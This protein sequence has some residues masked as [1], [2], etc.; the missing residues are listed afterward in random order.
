MPVTPGTPRFIAAMVTAQV[1]TQ[2]GGFTLPALPPGDM[3]SWSLSGTQAGWLI[4]IFFAA[5]VPF[6]A[7]YVPAVPVLLALTDRVPARR[8]C[9]VGT[10]ARA[11]WPG[12][13]PSAMSRWRCWRAS[14]CRA[15]WAAPRDVS[16][17]QR[18]GQVHQP[19]DG[20]DRPGRQ[21]QPWR[22]G[23]DAPGKG[24]AAPA[25]RGGRPCTTP[26]DALHARPCSRRNR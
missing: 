1:L 23:A 18:A 8:I 17:R 21:A 16:G 11:R 5:Y 9:L 10:G 14:P 6:F 25:R 7:A 22:I 15:G 19:G 24:R 12:A 3:E 2:I 20:G 4:G 13:S 26:A